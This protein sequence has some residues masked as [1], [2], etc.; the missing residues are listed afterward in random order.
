M[1]IMSLAVAK[2]RL[3]E[4]VD[5]AVATHR[6]VTITQNG[7][8]AVVVIA[9]EELEAI[10]ETRYWLTQPGSRADAAAGRA[11]DAHGLLDEAF[12]RRKFG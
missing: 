3:D 1:T 8:P 7:R 12:V 11:A 9:A 10:E 2:A 6:R 4:L 5:E